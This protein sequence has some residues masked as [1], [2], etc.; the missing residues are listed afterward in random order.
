MKGLT[1]VLSLEPRVVKGAPNL[2]RSDRQDAIGS[3]MEGDENHATALTGEIVFGLAQSV[4]AIARISGVGSRL[5]S[6]VLTECASHERRYGIEADLSNLVAN[7]HH[8]S[9]WR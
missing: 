8:Q 1:M 9:A 4:R 7:G 2:E 5:S 3:I 6:A